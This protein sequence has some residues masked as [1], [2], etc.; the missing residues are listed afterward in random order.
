[1]SFNYFYNIIPAFLHSKL[2]I[3]NYEEKRLL[4]NTNKSY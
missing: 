1:M 4:K 3:T 2:I